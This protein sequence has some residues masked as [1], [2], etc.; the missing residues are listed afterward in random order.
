MNEY[1]VN[2]LIVHRTDDVAWL[3]NLRGGD[4]PFN[5]VFLSFAIVSIDSVKL[6]LV[7]FIH[8]FIHSNFRLFVDLNKLSDSIK[9]DL[10]NENVNLYSYDLFYEQLKQDVQLQDK[11]HKFCVIFIL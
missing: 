4:I 10:E 6:V 8:L 1:Q 7:Y 2:N 11:S 5:P 3:F 9:K